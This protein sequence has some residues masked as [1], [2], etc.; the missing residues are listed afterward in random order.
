MIRP[1]HTYATLTVSKAAYYEIRKLLLEV[2]YNHAIITDTS[3]GEHGKEVI[4][5]HGIGLVRD[6]DVEAQPLS[7]GGR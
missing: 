2:N 4:D 3:I 6:D 5:M 1:T 7:E